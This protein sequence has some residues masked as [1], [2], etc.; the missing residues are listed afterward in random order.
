MVLV[1]S[2]SFLLR[3]FLHG[4][5]GYIDGHLGYI[6][7]LFL[8][9]RL[10]RVGR[11]GGDGGRER[12]G[13][14][15][16]G[17]GGERVELVAADVVIP[18]LSEGGEQEGEEDHDGEEE[19]DAGVAE[20][21]D[22]RVDEEGGAERR[23]ELVGEDVAVVAGEVERAEG[24]RRDGGEHRVEPAHAQINQADPQEE[25]RLR[26]LGG[27]RERADEHGGAETE[28][29]HGAAVGPLVHEHA[30]QRTEHAVAHRRHRPRQHQERTVRDERLPEHLPVRRHERRRQ[31]HQQERAPDLP[32]LRRLQRFARFVRVVHHRAAARDHVLPA[33]GRFHRRTEVARRVARA[34][35]F[36]IAH[37]RNHVL[38]HRGQFRLRRLHHQQQTDRLQH[39][40]A[41]R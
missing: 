13:G 29:R 3:F 19:R 6:D 35:R 20:N 36:Q 5:L 14:G 38:L 31:P 41:T 22:E 34:F 40:V 24:Q 15:E 12:D 10:G 9:G 1:V 28:E 16:R 21:A 33:R 37:D 30:P 18:L 23:D 39:H 11:G 27:E 4:L 7:G 25:E 8:R 26:E 2:F 17:G 32:E